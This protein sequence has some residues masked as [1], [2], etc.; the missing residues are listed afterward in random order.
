MKKISIITPVYNEEKNLH[1][2]FDAIKNL[3]YSK[4]DFEIIFIND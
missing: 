1:T 3:D 2:Y 4:E